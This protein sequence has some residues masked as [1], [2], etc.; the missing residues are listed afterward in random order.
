MP[1]A[2]HTP[3]DCGEGSYQPGAKAP[4]L[5][6][7]FIIYGLVLLEQTWLPGDSGKMLHLCLGYGSRDIQ[8]CC[9][10]EDRRFGAYQSAVLQVLSQK[11]VVIQGILGFP[12]HPVNWPFVHLVL[13]SSK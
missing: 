12:C 13:D 11:A 1:S 6:E 5:A 7:L 2:Q 3:D 9:T 8:P 4:D 10:R